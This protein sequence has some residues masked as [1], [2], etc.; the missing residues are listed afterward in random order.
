MS[1]LRRGLS[2]FAL[3]ISALIIRPAGAAEQARPA[4]LPARYG[5]WLEEVAPLISPRER[6]VFLSLQRDYQRD[7][8]IQRFWAVRDPFPQTVRNELRDAWE[9]RARL[10][11]ERYGGYG[12]DRARMLLINGEP[13]RTVRSHCSDLLLPLEAWIYNGT[14]RIHGGF[15]LVFVQPQ[16]ALRGPYRLWAPSEGLDA[17]LNLDIKARAPG[18][19]RLNTIAENC[20]Q[21]QEIAGDIASAV[22]WTRL[23]ATG[24]VLPR[25]ADEWLS[26]FSSY[27]TDVPA[28]A[29]SLPAQI[30]I[31]Y[32]G[33][34]GSRTVV[35]GLVR[36]P[37]EA[38]EPERLQGN[39][40]YNFLVDGEVLRRDELFEHFRY[41]FSLPASQVPAQGE[42]LIPLVF[43]RYLR[44]GA[45]TLI[46]KV[47]DSTGRRFFRDQRDLDVPAAAEGALAAVPANPAGGAGAV[48]GGT[49]ADAAAPAADGT[50]PA[51]GATSRSAAGRAA[52]ADALPELAE[53]NASL[54]A[55]ERT[56]RILP[57]PQELLTGTLRVEA[58]TTGEE[59][60]RVSFLL[61]GRPVLAKSHA[62]YSVELNLGAQPRLHLLKA[63]A[64]SAS[65]EKLA[66][67]QVVLNAGPHRFS[68]RLTEP[69]GGKT[70]RASLRAQAQVEVPEGETL[71]R[72]EFFLNDTRVATLFQAPFVQP[73]LIPQSGKL[74][75]VRAVAYLAGGNSAEDGVVINSPDPVERLDLHFVELYTTVV[76]R[77]GLTVEG[78]G[79]DDFKV[80]E[81]GVEQTVRRFELVRDLPIFA[82]VLLDTS[83][84]MTDQLD[85]AVNGALSFFQTVIKPRDRAAVITFASQPNLAVRFTNNQEVLAGGL[86][87]LTA[88]GNTVLY[89]TVIFT[90]HYFGG[91]R[92]KQAIILLTDGKDEGSRHSYSEALDYARRSLV[93]FYPVGLGI[94]SQPDIRL[95]L[96]QLAEETGGH[97]FFIERSSDLASIYKSIEKELRSQYLVAYQSS[98]PGNDGKFRA[99]E[100]KLS[101]PGLEAKTMRG[102]YP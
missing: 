15:V 98:K 34:Y 35:Q 52:R 63:M 13:A 95:K 78:L 16:G 29:P 73:I 4:E 68:V 17:L 31:S 77:R 60:G 84:S 70:Y 47:E 39:A 6:A 76:N 71:E 19:T 72:V 64:L 69:Q 89:D 82:A 25:P 41:R 96:Q 54:H 26:E 85:K 90:L 102:Y 44:P 99:V 59:I 80:Y 9:E 28:G 66:E 83:G 14:D 22:E 43:Q 38:V 87:G 23:E 12:E 37:R 1:G 79:R 33:R 91:I 24:K 27:S 97:S 40:F 93:A 32:P 20:P 2:V 86:A 18:R 62:P 53:A 88:G 75:Y 51:A 42:P 57:T 11:K 21:G 3:S 7:A 48:M 81:D 46:V 30:E 50:A 94:A 36:V 56:I 61:D 5:E 49:P 65:G 58:V 101:R 92:G 10:A 45:Y 74:S 8:F 67:D 100:V 55:A